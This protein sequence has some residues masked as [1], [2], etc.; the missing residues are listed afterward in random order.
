[1]DARPAASRLH[2]ARCTD[3]SVRDGG[4]GA[5][6]VRARRRGRGHGFADNL[7]W[8]ALRPL[9][10]GRFL[11]D[12]AALHRRAAGDLDVAALAVAGRRASFV[13]RIV[14]DWNSDNRSAVA[15]EPGP[16]A[17]ER[18]RGI[19]HPRITA[20]PARSR[21]RA[22]WLRRFGPRCAGFASLWLVAESPSVSPC[23]AVAIRPGA[24]GGRD[25]APA[26]AS[27]RMGHSSS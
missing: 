4:D 15:S 20:L 21:A 1:M 12:G 2:A 14:Y 19:I 24:G 22:F 5:S 3:R 6:A 27:V 23:G 16:E 13:R 11:G 25:G 26:V 8:M 10:R 9:R 17:A 7:F 18:L